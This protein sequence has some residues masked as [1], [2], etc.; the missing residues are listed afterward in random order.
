MEDGSSNGK[1]LETFTEQFAMRHNL[2]MSWVVLFAGADSGGAVT[3]LDR[4]YIIGK[5][6]TPPGCLTGT[7]TFGVI[8]ISCIRRFNCKLKFD[9]SNGLC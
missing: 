3:F 5:T 2:L 9:L 7:L 4:N 6:G 1:Y 8:A